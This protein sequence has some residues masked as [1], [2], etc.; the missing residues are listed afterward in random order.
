MTLKIFEKEHRK[1]TIISIITI[2]AITTIMTILIIFLPNLT[3]PDNN[4]GGT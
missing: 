4:G 1:K 2:L 3:I